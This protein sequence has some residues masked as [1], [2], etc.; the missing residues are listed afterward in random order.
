MRKASSLSAHGFG[1]HHLTSRAKP[2]CMHFLADNT[3]QRVRGEV[4]NAHVMLYAA[5]A[6]QRLAGGGGGAP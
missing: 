5:G 3:I 6:G 1:S 4:G 2:R